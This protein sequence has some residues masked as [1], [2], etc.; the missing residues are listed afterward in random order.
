MWTKWYEVFP[1]ASPYHSPAPT[2]SVQTECQYRQ[3]IIEVSDHNWLRTH[4]K[5]YTNKGRVLNSALNFEANFF[6]SFKWE[7]RS[8]LYA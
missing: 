5:S 4:D 8:D 6:C 2:K 1:A 7:K 3:I